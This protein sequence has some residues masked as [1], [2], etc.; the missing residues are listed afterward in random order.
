MFIGVWLSQRVR[1]A[2]LT[3]STSYE[4]QSLALSEVEWLDDIISYQR[5]CDGGGE[6]G[7]HIPRARGRP[8]RT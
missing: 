8:T 2:L 5:S 3:G 1:A 4:M 7:A 6:L